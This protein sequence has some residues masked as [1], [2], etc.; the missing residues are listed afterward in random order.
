MAFPVLFST[1][2]PDLSLQ[3]REK[4][5]QS[6]G[7]GCGKSH[8]ILSIFMQPSPEDRIFLVVSVKLNQPR[9]Q[10]LVVRDPGNEVETQQPG[11]TMNV[12][13]IA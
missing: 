9:S 6:T 4:T 10:S 12:P 7:N 1:F 11:F 13:L 2:S 8:L 3:A 5:S